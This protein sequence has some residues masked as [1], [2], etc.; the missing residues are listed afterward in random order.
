MKTIPFLAC[1]SKDIT[2]YVHVFAFGINALIQR[3]A[4]SFEWIDLEL[5][6]D[7]EGEAKLLTTKW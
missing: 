2:P 6:D 5:T 4:F 1:A 3:A 7:A